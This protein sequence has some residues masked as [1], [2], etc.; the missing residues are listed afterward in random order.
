MNGSKY[1]KFLS[2][3]R[4]TPHG[5][6]VLP[7]HHTPAYGMLFLSDQAC[8]LHNEYGPFCL[9]RLA[10]VFTRARFSYLQ[11]SQHSPSRIFMP[12][13]AFSSLQIP[14]KHYSGCPLP[15][16][17]LDPRHFPDRFRFQI[18]HMM[19]H[20]EVKTSFGCLIFLLSISISRSVSIPD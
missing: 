14:H 6:S 12:A 4:T 3:S 16:G 17:Y 7:A 19:Q 10:N 1:D 18:T 15:L 20:S 13:P 2:V 8:S 9:H 11:P 5:S